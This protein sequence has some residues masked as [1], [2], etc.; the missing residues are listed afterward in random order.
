MYPSFP[1]IYFPAILLLP[2]FGKF[3]HGYHRN[4]KQDFQRFRA[5]LI[6]KNRKKSWEKMN[7]LR[8]ELD[9]DLESLM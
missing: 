4:F 5:N 3:A 8:E 2:I 7:R 9:K 1:S 6:R